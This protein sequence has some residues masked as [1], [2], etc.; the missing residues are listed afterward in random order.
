MTA[1]TALAGYLDWPGVCQVF[2]LERR[3][4]QVKRGVVHAETVYGLTDLTPS[5]ASASDLLAYVRGHWLIENRS[6]WQRDVVF[7]EDRSQVRVGSIPQVMAAL[8]NAVIGLL[9]CSDEPRIAAATRR[10]AA[11]PWQALHLLGVTRDN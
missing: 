3:R 8:R 5:Q 1:S 2:R 11:Q 4:V 9:R 10:F 7:D 6:H